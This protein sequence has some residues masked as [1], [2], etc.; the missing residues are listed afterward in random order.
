[1]RKLLIMLVVCLLPVSVWAWGLIPVSGGIGGTPFF[2]DTFETN[3]FSNWT[4]QSTDGGDLSVSSANPLYGTYH[5]R[6]VR[7]DANQIYTHKNHGQAYSTAVYLRFFVE[8]NEVSSTEPNAG[9]GYQPIW[10]FNYAETQ[11]TG[12]L[13]FIVNSD[14]SRKFWKIEAGVLNN[15]L[16]FSN[17]TSSEI[18]VNATTI[19][20]VRARWVKGTSSDGILQ[21]WFGTPGNVSL[22]LDVS[23][24]DY[25]DSWDIGHTYFGVNASGSL[26]A[27]NTLIIDYD[28]ISIGDEQI[29]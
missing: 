1:M 5:L 28:N 3:D 20:E 10:F 21:V 25:W 19:Y 9:G 6:A 27:W 18:T 29:W 14:A 16:A 22:V 8:F 12:R 2:S 11:G 24:A 7:D 13:E 17:Y 26:N 23:T 4:S 15:S